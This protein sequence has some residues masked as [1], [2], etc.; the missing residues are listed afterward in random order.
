MNIIRIFHVNINCTDVARSK[1]FYEEFV[2]LKAGAH[3]VPD[4][5][6]VE[7]F[8]IAMGQWDAY[9]LDDGSP[10]APVK[11]DLLEW[12]QPRPVGR[13]YPAFNH[14]G[15]FRLCYVTRDLDAKYAKFEAA[16]IECFSRPRT[17]QLDAEPGRSVRF[18]CARD[19]D[20][21][22]IEFV[23]GDSDRLS[24]VNVNC[25]D[26][27][28]SRAF[29][30]EI[31]GFPPSSRSTPPPQ[32]GAA[33][34]YDGEVAWD[35]FF[36]TEVQTDHRFIIDL[37]EWKQP[38]PFGRP[39]AEANHLGIF[40]LAMLVPDIEA[41]YAELRAKGVPCWSPPEALKMGPGLPTVKALLLS[42]PD[43]ATLELIES[44]RRR[45]SQ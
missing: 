25:S 41:A 12:K 32:P 3:T 10:G 1:A 16:G 6:P 4:L 42:D 2:G 9:M 36:F 31:L 17:L 38:R 22:V 40:R 33:F 39:Y 34:G 29:Y 7:S 35:A 5:Q 45:P 28:R 23:A 26:L 8:R 24:H 19:P 44:P 21:T 18:F 30:A 43:G 37:L 20:G 13:P 14:L 27:E 15:F 11:L